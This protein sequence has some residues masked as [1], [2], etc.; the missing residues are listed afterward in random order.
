MVSS[1]L[2]VRVIGMLIF[3]ISEDGD[4]ITNENINLDTN[5]KIRA[6]PANKVYL[7]SIYSLKDVL[8]VICSDKTNLEI[9]KGVED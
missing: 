6:I 4:Y 5:T 3:N 9:S 7:S 1:K 2:T 8:D